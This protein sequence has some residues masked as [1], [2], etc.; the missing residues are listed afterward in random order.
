MIFTHRVDGNSRLLYIILYL[1]VYNVAPIIPATYLSVV[2]MKA[3][4]CRHLYKS[5]DPGRIHV[6]FAK[7]FFR[8]NASSTCRQLNYYFILFTQ[9]V[10]TGFVLVDRVIYFEL[11]QHH[12]K[13]VLMMG[14]LLERFHILMYQIKVFFLYCFFFP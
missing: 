10:S 1:Y 8:T 3:V 6:V 12:L 4:L 11:V 9:Y 7:L 2:Q 14:C 5:K 13:P